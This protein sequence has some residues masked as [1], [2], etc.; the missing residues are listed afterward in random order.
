MKKEV[1]C[2]KC[3]ITRY[4]GIKS[5]VTELCRS[6]SLIGKNVGK[7][8]SAEFKINMSKLKS[9]ENNSF[10]G[11]HHSK[12]T[13][14]KIG[15]YNRTDEIK[16]QARKNLLKNKRDNSRSNY[17]IWIEKYGYE[18]ANEKNIQLKSKQSILNSGSKNNMFGK[19][20]PVGS[21]NGWSGWYKGEYFRSL[22]ELSFL[23]YIK[24]EKISYES[25]ELSKHK[26]E[27]ELNGKS[28]NYFCD[29]YL[30]DKNEHIEIK[31][32]KL[33][34]T[35]ENIAKFKA[36]S[37]QY[38]K[39][40]ILTEENIKKISTIELI[41]IYKTGELVWIERYKEKFIKRFLS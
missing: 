35:V 31:P 10:Y 13:K 33:C 20:P 14:L 41:E 30:I 34:N 7:V 2:Q 24:N 29:F 25:G 27:F 16:N 11:K 12:E 40:T 17:S 32:K 5:K 28:K 36:A 1:I 4:V 26:V 9:G 37:E 15:K 18:I 38:T 3:N 19:P 8:R 23:I 6:C 39:F 22:L 21:G